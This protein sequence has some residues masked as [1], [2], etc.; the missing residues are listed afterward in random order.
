GLL[1]FV[2]YPVTSSIVYSFCDYSVLTEPRFVG[3]SNYQELI[4]D[5]VFCV[6]M[7]NTA[8]YAAFALPLGLFMA[9]SLAL[10]LSSNV[11]AVGLDRTFLFLPSLTPLVASA[12]VWLWIFNSQYGVLN[13]VLSTLTFGL[14]HNVAWL[15][16]AR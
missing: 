13:H 16:D 9:F 2:L 14:V 6:A 5:R 15:K 12:M 4:G 1:V 7:K 3:L 8:I 10:L 11:K